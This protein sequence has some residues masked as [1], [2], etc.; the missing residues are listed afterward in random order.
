MPW[1]FHESTNR[2]GV[3]D[4]ATKP[5]LVA[6]LVVVV[7]VCG[8]APISGAP[9]DRPGSGRVLSQVI[10]IHHRRAYARPPWAGG[11][12]GGG[13]GK[14]DKGS[15]KYISRGMRWK[16]LED[17][18]VNPTNLDGLSQAFVVNSMAGAMDEWEAYGGT[19]FGNLHVD[20]S[21][22]FNNGALDDV[23]TLTFGPWP[24]D[25]VI[26]VTSV[27]GFFDGPPRFREIVETDLL[28]NEDYVWGD[29]DV[30]DSLMDLLNIAVHE[31]GHCA[32]MGDLYEPGATLETMYGRSTEGEI[33]KRDLYF[34]D[35]D[36]IEKLYK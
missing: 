31:V 6:A 26:A 16:V 4:E 25:N 29:A 24:D 27:W 19:I 7:F 11:G 12:G 5:L 30:D 32:G 18:Y 9:K 13:G 34:G 20:Y 33:I 15:Y 2:G 17:V 23:N 10:F 36:G 21:A 8:I 35:I 28:F 1:G 14:E 22:S 3:R